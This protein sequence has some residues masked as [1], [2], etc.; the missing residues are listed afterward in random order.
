MKSLTPQFIAQLSFSPDQLKTIRTIGQYRGNQELFAKQKP[1][2]LT[3][4]SE[5]AKIE[6]TESSNRIEGI[7]ASYERIEHL[8]LQMTAPKNRSEQEIAG[9][10]DAL[11]LIHECAEHMDISKNVILQ[12]HAILCRYTANPGGIFKMTDNEIVEKDDKGQITTVRF[13]VLS[14]VQTS[15]AVAELCKQYTVLEHEFDP[16][17]TIPLFMLDFLCIHPFYDGNGR[18]SRLLTLLLLCRAGYKVG[19]YISLE[20]IIEQSKESYYATLNQSSQAWHEGTH[21]VQPW[22]DYFWSIIVAAYKE[23][24]QRA[25]VYNQSDKMQA[26]RIIIMQQNKAFSLKDCSTLC[27]FASTASIKKVLYRLKQE[28][29]L[30]LEG[31]GAMARWHR[32]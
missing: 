8:V 10:R 2:T 20:R 3:K 22:L 25:T 29:L 27:P 23:F 28:G 32:I 15:I 4:L 13:K 18:T 16:L 12:L 30:S 11:T 17:I 1:E 31:K 21:N 24:E 19:N 26:I 7:E 14:A 5:I 6:S 9:Y